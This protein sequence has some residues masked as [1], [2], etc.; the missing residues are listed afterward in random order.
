MHFILD[1]ITKLQVIT[2]TTKTARIRNVLIVKQRAHVQ[3]EMTQ[4]VVVRQA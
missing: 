3:E 1:Q 4:C 2:K